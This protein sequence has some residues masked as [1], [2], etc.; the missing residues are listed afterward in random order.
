[1]RAHTYAHA[2]THTRARTPAQSHA[3]TYR[4]AD[5]AREINERHF[6]ETMAA[7]ATLELTP[8]QA[9]EVCVCVC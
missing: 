5:K 1:M 4:W 6:A 8:E 7:A 2:H 9:A 3:N